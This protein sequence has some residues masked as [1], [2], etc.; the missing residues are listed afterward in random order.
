MAGYDALIAVT[1]A[2]VVTRALRALDS[3][4][5]S[6]SSMRTPA[7]TTTHVREQADTRA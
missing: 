7:P 4:R 1:P 5:A 3:K 2:P 6:R